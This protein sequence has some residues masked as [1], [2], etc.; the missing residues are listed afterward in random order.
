ME[1]KFFLNI[2]NGENSYA[3]KDTVLKK[4]FLTI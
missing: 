2:E 1:N 4:Q 3:N